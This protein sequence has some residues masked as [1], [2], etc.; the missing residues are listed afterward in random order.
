MPLPTISLI[1]AVDGNHA[2]YNVE[3]IDAY[4][5]IIILVFPKVIYSEIKY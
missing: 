3:N 5:G 2:L 1:V 4:E